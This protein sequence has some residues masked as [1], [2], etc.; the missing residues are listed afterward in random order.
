[1]IGYEALVKWQW[2]GKPIHAVIILSSAT[3]AATSLSF[4]SLLILTACVRHRR[5]FHGLL[6]RRCLSDDRVLTHTCA[7]NINVATSKFAHCY[8]Y[9]GM[10]KKNVGHYFL[11][12]CCYRLVTNFC[13]LWN[14]NV[15]HC[16][17]K[18][19]TSGFILSWFNPVHTFAVFFFSTTLFN[20]ITVWVWV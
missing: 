5:H 4:F 6:Q 17:L 20:I 15:Q 1:M 16:V 14:P 11:C 8:L 9:S 12:S 3:F 18:V 19:Q 10:R 13:T 2:Q 7:I